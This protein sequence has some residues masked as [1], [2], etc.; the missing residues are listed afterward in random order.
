MDFPKKN[1]LIHFGNKDCVIGSVCNFQLLI[2]ASLVL[3][4]LALYPSYG[5]SYD[6]GVYYFPGWKSD[7]NY[8]NDLKGLPGS[9]SPG[10][11]WQDREPVLGYYPEEET[12]VAE[13]H[14]EW[15]SKYGIDFFAYD[16][17]WDGKQSPLEHALKAY[18][19]AKNKDKLKFC[20]LWANHSVVPRN[21]E[22]FDG[23]VQYWIENYFNQ[24][25]FYVI[26]GKPVI[27]IFSPSELDQNA[28][29]FG[30]SARSLLIRANDIAKKKG[31]SGIY[32]VA[33]TNKKP[34]DTLEK[35]LFD[36]GYN[37]YTGWNYVVSKDKSKVA[38]YDSMVN[39]YVDFY[40]L[41]SKTAKRLPYI[42]PASPGWD[43]R[44]WKG[45]DA[46]VRENPTPE[47]FEK[48]LIGA[49]KLIDS[50]SNN[51][52]KLLMIEAWNEFGEGSYI[53]PTK[54]WGMRYLETIQKVFNSGGAQP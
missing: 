49:K 30:E 35:E 28:R 17:Y 12:W 29:K 15:A 51:L 7:S 24:P 20:L 43:S 16:W 4:K 54:K 45:K 13:K 25:T 10:I 36:Q 19:N 6:I 48:M 33:V 39:T 31:I 3:L 8:W 38:D 5:F 40:N 44:P 34:S 22:E 23:M 52:P 11:P 53:E 26:D 37:A 18:L 27:F 50:Q 14:I 1:I 21:L 42:V 2:A 46:Y 41:S 9:R 47:K 32:F